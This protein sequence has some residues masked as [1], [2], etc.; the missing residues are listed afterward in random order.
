[1]KPTRKRAR[2][3]APVPAAAV[4]QSVLNALGAS[5][6]RARL[7]HL[8]QNWDMVMGPELASL[9]LP[10]GARGNTLLL[11]A[12]DS[13]AIQELHLQN[14]EILE[15]VNAFMESPFFRAVN[16]SLCPGRPTCGE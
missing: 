8:W 15:R 3:E 11:G 5:P 2:L 4:L 7:F 12:P 6:E 10:M 14:G 9:A 13:I 16:I 1:M